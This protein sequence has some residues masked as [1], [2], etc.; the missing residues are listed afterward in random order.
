M[1][2]RLI[3]RLL[4]NVRRRE[5]PPV[6]SLD[7]YIERIFPQSQRDYARRFLKAFFPGPY[8]S[9]EDRELYGLV[10]EENT[11]R[12]FELLGSILVLGLCWPPVEHEDWWMIGQDFDNGIL[13]VRKSDGRIILVSWQGDSVKDANRS[14]LS[15]YFFGQTPSTQL[16]T[17]L[18]DSFEQFIT[19]L[20]MAGATL[21]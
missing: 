18:A 21:P 3:Q 1:I 19:R 15:L 7:E 10:D 12:M 8:S 11:T 17:E 13:A 9:W 2:W 4:P 14:L 5:E 16:V 20:K 6:L